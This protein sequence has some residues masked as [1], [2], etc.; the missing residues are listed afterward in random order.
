[1]TKEI[2]PTNSLDHLSSGMYNGLKNNG[3]LV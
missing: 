3:I 2:R 1:V